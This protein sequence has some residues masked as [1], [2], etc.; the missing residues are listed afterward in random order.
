MELHSVFLFLQSVE[1]KPRRQQLVA[2]LPALR[3]LNG[4]RITETEREDAERAF[5]RVYMDLE[6]PPPR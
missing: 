4:S 2:R 1:Q 3:Q 5:I 6:S